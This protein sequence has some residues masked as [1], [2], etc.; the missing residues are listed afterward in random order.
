MMRTRMTGIILLWLLLLQGCMQDEDL[1]QFDRLNT[2][3]AQEGVF[4]I[5]EGNFT[6]GNASVSFY[7]PATGEVL[8]DVF[9]QTNALPLGD[10][11]FSMTLRDTLG[12]VV[13]NNSGR[14]YVMNTSTFRYTGKITGLTSPRYM[15]FISDEKAYV[16]DL[17]TRAITVVNPVTREIT[18]SIDVSNGDTRFNQH[19]TE[20]MVQ[21]DRYVF[22][23]CWS[24]DDK[25][26]VIDTGKDEVVDSIVVL[27]QPNSLV[28]DRKHNLWVLC[29]GGYE[30]S[31]YGSEEGGLMRVP[32]GEREARLVHRF[33]PGES[34]SG[35]TTDGS[36]EVLYFLNG[37]VY[38]MSIYGDTIPELLVDGPENAFGMGYY[39]LTVDPATSEIYVSDAIDFVQRGLVYRF[40]AG[41]VPLDTF[42]AGIVPTSFC[43]KPARAL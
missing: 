12:F 18:G 21:Y 20:Q 26:L 11:A 15:H 23:N 33:A 39:G 9:Y 16:T 14:I 43:F 2:N 31:P 35:L 32:A 17:Y 41:G 1:R 19:S 7:D 28:L 27:K 22:T 37:G 13:V 4:V 8:N 36:R 5:N 42:R 40:D 3:L 25:I 34:P 29:D 10:V 38:R 6:Y 24:Y 30:G